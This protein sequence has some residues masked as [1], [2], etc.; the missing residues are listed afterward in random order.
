M[1]EREELLAV[2][3]E[4]APGA[5]QVRFDQ[6]ERKRVVAGGHRRVRREH[7]R[8]PHFVERGLEASHPRSHRS[9][10]RC[11]DDERG[12]PF[13]EVIDRRLGA[14]R[15]EHAHA[16]DAEDD[17]LLHARLAI[18]AVEARRQLAIPRRVLLEVR[19][20][21]D[22]AFTRPTRTRQTATSTVRL[23]SGTAV[24]HGLPS[25]VSAGSIGASV[26]FSFS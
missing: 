5:G 11:S 16:A 14:Q 4:V 10:M 15:L 18:A 21:Q 19:V 17:L 25:G 6:V 12:V 2:L 1:A 26:Q 3:A 13:V 23:P 9:R 8:P 22:T 24:T 7:R 20:E